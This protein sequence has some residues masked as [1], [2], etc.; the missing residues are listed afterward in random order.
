[1]PNDVYRWEEGGGLGTTSL[2]QPQYVPL[3]EL[4]SAPLPHLQD[5]VESRRVQEPVLR[6]ARRMVQPVPHAAIS[7]R[8][9]GAPRA[10]SDGVLGIEIRR[11]AGDENTC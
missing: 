10:G 2:K 11:H 5:S 1:M 6:P 8:Y 9:G 7:Q 4:H 3:T